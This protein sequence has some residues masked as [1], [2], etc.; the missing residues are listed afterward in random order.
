MLMC[1]MI[2]STFFMP[3]TRKAEL[4]RRIQALELSA[5]AKT[6]G[7]T[8]SEDPQAWRTIL[9]GTNKRTRRRRRQKKRWKR[10]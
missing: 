4:E 1:M 9:Q 8:T 3:V 2:L 5:E 10:T 7:M 6:D